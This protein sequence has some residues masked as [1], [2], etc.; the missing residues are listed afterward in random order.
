MI[1]RGSEAPRFGFIFAALVLSV[2]V[3]RTARAHAPPHATGIQWLGERAII[4]TNR[5]LIVEDEVGSSFRLLCNDAYQASLSETVPFASTSDG[6]IV[7]ASYAAGIALST[8][9]HCSFEPATGPLTGLI[10]LDLA[11]DS[12]GKFRAAIYPKDDSTPALFESDDDGRSFHHQ[13]D[14]TGV[15]TSVRVAPSDPG[16]VY[17]SSSVS[18]GS[19]VTS[20][21]EVSSDG[22]RV[23]RGT[24]IELDP[25][26]LRAIVLGVDALDPNRV[27]MRTQSRDGVTPE[28]LL[29]GNAQAGTLET[30]FAGPGPLS[31]TFSAD[32]R[33]WVGSAHGLYRFSE[34]DGTFAAA[35]ADL[36]R[37]GC[38]ASRANRLYVCAYSA[39]EFG[40]LVSDNE[41]A[42][43]D[44]FLR[45][46][47]VSARL[48]CP[49][50]SHEG[51]SCEA[52]F[53][54]WSSEQGLLTSEGGAAGEPS[55]ATGSSGAGNGALP[56]RVSRGCAVSTAPRTGMLGA[57]VTAGALASFLTLLVQRRRRRLSL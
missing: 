8:A 40:V 48:D 11:L 31:M 9:D 1:A 36:S 14:L 32:G 10:V 28:R 43:F 22:G 26:E 7:L 16:R 38:L 34:A 30:L 39:G 5:G 52:A 46:P 57:L 24:P 54:D 56:T 47:Q 27:F 37:I 51:T 49:A 55:T 21:L 25:S 33:L 29:V 15:P 50:T 18:S 44:W 13:A 23:F 45:F 53:F 4:R 20:S 6:R 42:S 3:V 19:S 2:A 17:V 12:R 41:A 35:T